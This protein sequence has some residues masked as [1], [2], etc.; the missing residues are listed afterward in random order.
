MRNK[1]WKSFV[2]GFLVAILMMSLVTT[3]MAASAQRQLEAWYSNIKI[4]LDGVETTPKDV[5]GNVVEP[6]VV[7]GTTY[8]PVRAVAN[9]LGLGVDWDGGTNTVILTTPGSKPSSDSGTVIMNENGIK[10]TY[11]GIEKSKSD[12]L[13]D[14]WDVKVHIENNSSKPYIVQVRNVSVN[15]VMVDDIF[16]P[17]VAAGKSVD[18]VITLYNLSAHGATTPIKNVEFYFII[19]DCDSWSNYFETDIVSIK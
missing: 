7:D 13:D 6:F 17:T 10:I 3:G 9:M 16:S 19:V 4:T 2:S 14:S 18:D 11:L 5:N 8:L 1:N 12:W 15:G